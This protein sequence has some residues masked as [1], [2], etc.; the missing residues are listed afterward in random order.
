MA[1][2]HDCIVNFFKGDDRRLLNTDLFQIIVALTNAVQLMQILLV[3]LIQ[4]IWCCGQVE[5]DNVPTVDYS[6]WLT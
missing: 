4:R 1:G 3:I 6:N 5:I 2:L